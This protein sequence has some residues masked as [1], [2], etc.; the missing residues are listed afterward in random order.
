MREVLS[1]EMFKVVEELGMQQVLV[2]FGK[3]L[4]HSSHFYYL[5]VLGGV[6]PKGEVGCDWFSISLEVLV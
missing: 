2:D 1:L 6:M 5:K 4:S 3:D